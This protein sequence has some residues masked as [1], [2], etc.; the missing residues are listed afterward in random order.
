MYKYDAV[1]STSAKNNNNININNNN[2][3]S[4]YYYYNN[5]TGRQ[6]INKTPFGLEFRSSNIILYFAYLSPLD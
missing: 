2:N 6:V 1:N 5:N 3:N 4:N